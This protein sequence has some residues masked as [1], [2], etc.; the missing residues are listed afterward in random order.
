MVPPP[1]CHSPKD[2]QIASLSQWTRAGAFQSAESCDLKRTAFSKLD[3]ALGAY[4]GLPPEQVYD[5]ECVASDDPRL[6][7]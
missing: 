4:P 2:A 7:P 5:A 3:P 1:L 6:K